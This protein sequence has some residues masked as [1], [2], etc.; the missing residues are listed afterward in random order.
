VTPR[1]DRAPRRARAPESHV[2]VLV[3]GGGPGGTSAAHWLGRCRRRVLLVDAGRPRN[4]RT[5]AIHGF[6]T[7]E[8]VSPRTY[9]RLARAELDAYPTVRRVRGTV[10]RVR[11][12]GPRFRAALSDGSRVRSRAVVLAPGVVDD[13]PRIP[14]F[15]AF[16]G[17][18]VFHC[19]YCD[20]FEWSDRPLAAYGRGS[21]G[22][23]LA[24]GLLGWSDDVVLFTDGTRVS[25]EDRARLEASGV[26]RIGAAVSALEGRGGSLRAVRLATGEVV[27]RRALFFA[28]GQW[29]RARLAHALGCAFDDRGAIAVSEEHATSVR[30]VYAVGDATRDSQFVVIAAAE[31]ARAAVAVNELLLGEDLLVRRFA[32]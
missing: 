27:P 32:R 2:D 5:R 10:E 6:P 4:A 16:Y 31:G 22:V 20:A 3:V 7:R 1:R 30:G 29:K 28:T 21:A 11:R 24:L 14:G 13:L 23:G 26:R 25:A 17:R 19:P 9:L 18:S 15:E 12:E 8:G